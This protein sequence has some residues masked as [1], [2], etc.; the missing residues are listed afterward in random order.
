MD[1]LKRQDNALYWLLG[2]NVGLFG[3][4]MLLTAGLGLNAEGAWGLF[5]NLFGSVSR[6]EVFAGEVARLVTANFL[7][8]DLLHLASNMYGLWYLG[9]AVQRV[10]GRK[11]LFSTYV[12]TGVAASVV[13]VA[14]TPYPSV[15]ASGA[16]FGLMGILI[17]AALR[18]SR[19]GVDFPFDWRQILPLVLYSLW[20]GFLAGGTINNW[21]HIGGLAVGGL[22]GYLLPRRDINSHVF[23]GRDVAF[24][25]SVVLVVVCYILQGIFIFSTLRA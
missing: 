9:E 8:A 7:H 10:F 6:G 25:F 24:Y 2:V 13:T 3:L 11:W 12:I 23:W 20:F 1:W 15:G 18:R 14:A 5:L 22:M 17:G 21:A 19:Y 16:V 4:I